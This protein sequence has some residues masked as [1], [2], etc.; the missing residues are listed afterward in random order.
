[1]PKN[2]LIGPSACVGESVTIDGDNFLP[3][4]NTTDS[5]KIGTLIITSFTTKTNTQL[6]FTV[7]PSASWPTPDVAISSVPIVASFAGEKNHTSGVNINP[8]PLG[9]PISISTPNG[10]TYCQGG[11]ITIVANGTLTPP[12]EFY[13]WFVASNPYD[14][15][16]NTN[17]QASIGGSYTL[18]LKNYQTQ[19]ETSAS[20]SQS[21]T[22][23]DTPQVNAYVSN[24]VVCL[25][26]PT[27]QALLLGSS[28]THA[29]TS[30]N[31]IW[32]AGGTGTFF[33]NTSSTPVKNNPYTIPSPYG[34]TI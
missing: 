11:Y 23:I 12:Y 20:P 7:P 9:L 33:N 15:T 10:T 30:N 29:S 28:V 22:Q 34:N 32:S 5:V 8:L 6:V 24:P 2:L 4:G 14:S 16:T 18:K 31:G 3:N 25:A 13:H 19:C 1:M 27:P 26:D 21:I 17:E